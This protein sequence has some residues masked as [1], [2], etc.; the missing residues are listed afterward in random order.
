MGRRVGFVVAVAV[1]LGSAGQL[2]AQTPAPALD[3]AQVVERVQNFY[4][5]TADYQADFTQTYFHRLFNK[6]QRSYGTVF[7]K[8]PGKMR[9]E[10]SRPERKLFVSDGATLWVFEPEAQQAF[11]QA[12]GESQL[13]TAITFLAG[14]GDIARDF[15]TRLLDARR[16]GYAQGHVLELRPHEPQPSFERI[17]FFVDGQ[18]F[19]VLRTLVLDAAGNRNRMDFSNVLLNPGVA[20]ARFRFTPP[21]GTRIIEP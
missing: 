1:V 6:T 16:N 15:R 14:G 10:Y 12:L 8:K 20:D 19:Q 18:S 2:P 5:S 9:W 13:P 7:I 21:N 17:L 11:R 4:E 3:A